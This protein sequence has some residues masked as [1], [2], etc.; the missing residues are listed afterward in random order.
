MSRRRSV[1]LLAL[2]C[3]CLAPRPVSAQSVSDVLTFLVTNQ[4]V[5]TGS[6]ER[7]QAAAQATS[8]T[9]ARALLANLATLPV[10]TASSGFVYRLNPDL[11]T[12]ERAS[13]TFGPFFV[14]RAITAGRG[15]ASIGLTFQQFHFTSIGGHNLRDG[16]LVTTANQFVDEPAPFDVDRLALNIDASVATLYGDFGVSDRLEVGFAA[17]VVSL[18]LDGSRVNTYRAASFTQATAAAHAV[19][20]ADLV[21]RAKFLAYREEGAAVAA[22]VDLRLPTGNSANLLGAGSSS[23]KFS[24]IGSLETGPVSSHVNLG[25]TVGGLANE[26]SYG[27]AVGIAASSHVTVLGE[28]LGRVI[29]SAGGLA[30]VSQPHPTLHDVQ[31]LR[32][33]P[34]GTWFNTVSIVPG[35]KWNL[36]GTWVLAANVTIPLTMAGLTAPLT[37]FVGLDYVLG[38]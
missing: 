1:G 2:A 8:A 32:L 28:L 14:E 17:P 16:S 30:T 22:A 15:Q 12:V 7:D 33:V 5:Q 18:N 10:A 11:G 23:A 21:V 36:T 31:T 37:P 27:G 34:D 35:L 38:R 24:A 29:R 3:I 20:L 6:I 9:I 19:G 26:L 25:A 13:D 4:A